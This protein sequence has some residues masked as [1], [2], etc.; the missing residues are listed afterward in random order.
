MPD[1]DYIGAAARERYAALKALEAQR[2]ANALQAA[3]GNANN[4]GDTVARIRA[5][6]A[7]G[8]FAHG[9]AN[10]TDPAI[11]QGANAAGI[12]PA[13]LA[14]AL[15]AR[16]GQLVDFSTPSNLVSGSS[17]TMAAAPVGMRGNLGLTPDQPPR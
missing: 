13:M 12:T 7:Q 2:E 1:N 6:D 16:G 17:G 9:A 15:R 10:L 8:G 14:A 5:I 11:A 4:T 3:Q